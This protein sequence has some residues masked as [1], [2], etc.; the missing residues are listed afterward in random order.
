[1]KILK[2]LS[3]LLALSLL[4]AGCSDYGK[5]VTKGP[6]EVYYKEGV[7]PEQARHTAELFAYIDSAQNNNSKDTKSMQLCKTN[8]I[9][10]F[11]M[12]SEKDK[13]AGVDDRSFYVIGNLVSDSIFNGSPVNVEL[14][15]NTF[16]TFKTFAYK[17]MDLNNLDT[18]QQTPVQPAQ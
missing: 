2:S 6:I 3:L 9:F 4:I 17:K 1:M 12:V 8:G 16:E 18:P 11:R 13:L 5:K 14:T 15:N 10:C 7:T